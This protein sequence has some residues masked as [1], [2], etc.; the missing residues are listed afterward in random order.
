MSKLIGTKSKK[1]Q[2]NASHVHIFWGL[3]YIRK[4]LRIHVNGMVYI[5][6]MK[7]DGSAIVILYTA[8]VTWCVT[9]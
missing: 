2:L 9:A 3:M 8:V 1:E 5:R 7:R 6:Q 4:V